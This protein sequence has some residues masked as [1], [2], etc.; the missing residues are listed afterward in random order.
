QLYTAMKDSPQTQV[1]D[2]DMWVVLKA[3][4]EQSL[5]NPKEPARF[6][7]NKDLFYLKKNGNTEA[8]KY[9]LS[10]Y[11]I[12][13]TPFSEDDHKELLTRW[14]VRLG[15]L[16][17]EDGW[18]SVCES[19]LDIPPLNL[20]LFLMRHA[21]NWPLRVK[22]LAVHSAQPIVEDVHLLMAIDVMGWAFV[23]Q[24]IV[25]FPGM[26][27]AFLRRSKESTVPGDSQSTHLLVAPVSVM[28]KTR[29]MIASCVTP[30]MLNKLTIGSMLKF[31]LPAISGLTTPGAWFPRVK[32]SKNEKRVVNIG[33]FPK[34]CDATLKKVL[35]KVREI[36]TEV[37]YGYKD[38]NLSTEDREIMEF[39]EEEIQERLK[40]R[41]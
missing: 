31:T 34:F 11:K 3:K 35:R 25:P 21:R 18:P 29:S 24:V 17:P 30:G 28:E 40:Y 41:D 38:P 12:H 6:L 26:I 32:A 9:A 4:F 33:E 39:F 8:K 27:K 22:Q 19:Y 5:R 15:F 20:S 16:S 37:R 13:A 1:V 14:V 23:K 7:Y 2:P 10:L 36:N